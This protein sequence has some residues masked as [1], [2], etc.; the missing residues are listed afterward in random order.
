L[1]EENHNVFFRNKLLLIA[2]RNKLYNDIQRELY[3]LNE[4]IEQAFD[5]IE[6]LNSEDNSGESEL[7]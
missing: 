1:N 6:K 3:R 5:R 4:D 7:I 2:R